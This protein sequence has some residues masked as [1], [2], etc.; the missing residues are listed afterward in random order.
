MR[1]SSLKV[2]PHAML[3][4]GISGIRRKTLIIN[5]PGSPRAACEN[6]LVVAPV[7]EHAVELL[8]DDPGAEQ[9][10]QPVKS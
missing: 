7:L 3:S 9:G 5:L 8:R 1:A 10:H 6:L 2:T 4:R